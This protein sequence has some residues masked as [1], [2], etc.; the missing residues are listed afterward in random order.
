[1]HLENESYQYHQKVNTFRHGPAIF[2][3][4]LICETRDCC[5]I[6]YI[7]T[8][9]TCRFLVRYIING[10]AISW[11][12]TNMCKWG[13]KLIIIQRSLREPKRDCLPRQ[14]AN[15]DVRE[16]K[17]T[18]M[19]VFDHLLSQIYLVSFVTNLHKNLRSSCIVF[20]LWIWI[21]AFGKLL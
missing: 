16:N 3:V 15:L 19:R 9:L 12:Y 7:F 17:Y 6:S 4:L 2:E 20:E 13:F 11:Y 8:W 10:T 1:M 21:I 14:H 5:F 18:R